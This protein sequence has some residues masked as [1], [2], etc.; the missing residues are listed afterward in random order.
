[1]WLTN[2]SC[3]N[4]GLIISSRY[5]KNS[6][7]EQQELRG[8]DAEGK[9]ERSVW[10]CWILWACCSFD[11]EVALAGDVSYHENELLWL[12]FKKMYFI[13]EKKKKKR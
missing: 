10:I 4:W 3:D 1:M 6:F 13:W 12:L 9:V 5:C 11:L 7:Q 8:I 2:L